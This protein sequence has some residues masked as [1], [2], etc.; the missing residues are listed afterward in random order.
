[1][2]Y[3]LNASLSSFCMASSSSSTINLAAKV[4]NSSNSSR[5]D[6]EEEKFYQNFNHDNLKPNTRELKAG[7]LL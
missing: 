3:N 4:T 2:S 7:K 1:M 5:P 6:S